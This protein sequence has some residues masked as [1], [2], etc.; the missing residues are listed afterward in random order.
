MNESP[1]IE[2]TGLSKAYGKSKVLDGID[3]RVDRGTVFSLLGPNGAGKTTTVRILATLTTADAGRARVAGYDIVADR[4]R[5]R[6][7]ISLT[8]QFAA[9]D[10]KQ[11][12]EEN[13][14]MMARLSGLSRRDARRRA[15]ELLER[16]DLADA[17]RRRTVTYSGGMRRRLDLAAGLVGDPEVVFLDEPTTG[18]DPRSRAEL[19]Q[20]VRDLSDRGATVFLTTQYLE[21]ADRLADRIAVVDGGRLVA[22][23]TAAELKARV[24]GHRLDLVL[25]DT[26]AYWRLE[27]RAVHRSPGTLT[28]G[29]PTDGTAAHVRALLD[30]VD[31]DRRDVTRFALHTA[32]LDDVFLALTGSP[33]RTHKEPA[34][35]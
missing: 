1:A 14:R 25:N 2:A 31:P 9:V 35:V 13:L 20:V 5:V 10:E 32:T 28:L 11:T 17:G 34:H 33:A 12:G 3:L 15:A 23:G 26:A 18:L 19:W 27:S 22:E 7:A 21:E 29:L 30:E 24:A 16:F 8:G 4:G 6:R